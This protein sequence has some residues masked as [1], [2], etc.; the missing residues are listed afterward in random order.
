MV[1]TNCPSMWEAETLR[2]EVEVRK[3]SIDP[4][5]TYIQTH[6]YT[7]TTHTQTHSFT[8]TYHIH[9]HKHTHTH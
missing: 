9:I 3:D 2:R 7:L 1:H 6:I 4:K 8:H 5:H